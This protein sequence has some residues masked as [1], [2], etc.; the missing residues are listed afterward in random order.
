MVM[1]KVDHGHGHDHTW[2]KS[3]TKQFSLVNL[4]IESPFCEALF[5][6]QPY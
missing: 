6:W 4:N 1:V 2:S 3:D 5:S